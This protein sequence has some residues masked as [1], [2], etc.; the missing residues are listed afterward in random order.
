LLFLLDADRL[1][2]GSGTGGVHQDLLLV[3]P[4]LLG[5]LLLRMVLQ[6]RVVLFLVLTSYGF[7]VIQRPPRKPPDAIPA[8]AREGTPEAVCAL[9]EAAPQVIE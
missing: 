1:Q 8:D 2:R 7:V 9:P 3:S 6:H 4:L 5:E